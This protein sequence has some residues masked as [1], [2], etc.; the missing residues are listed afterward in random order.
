MRTMNVTVQWTPL[1]LLSHE[2]STYKTAF[3][4][5]T[6]AMYCFHLAMHILFVYS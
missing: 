5:P 1:C 4:S 2:P 6:A 3:S